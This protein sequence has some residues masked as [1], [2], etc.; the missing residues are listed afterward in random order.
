[1]ATLT[2][3]EIE[4]NVF[5]LNMTPKKVSGGLTPL[6]VFVINPVSK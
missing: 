5:L 3:K 2:D 4:D 1:M 6:E